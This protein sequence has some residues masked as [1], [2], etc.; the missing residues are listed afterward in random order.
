[1]CTFSQLFSLAEQQLTDQFAQVLT[2]PLNEDSKGFL[3]QA[4]RLKPVHSPTSLSCSV[5]NMKNM[6]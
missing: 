5:L 3:G 1:M 2:G 6:T 4:I